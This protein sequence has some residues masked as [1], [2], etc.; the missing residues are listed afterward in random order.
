MKSLTD[1]PA[2]SFRLSDSVWIAEGR[3]GMLLS[4]LYLKGWC[5]SLSCQSPDLNTLARL[6]NFPLF[7]SWLNRLGWS[8]G[9]NFES[10]SWSWGLLGF[11]WVHQ[12]PL[13]YQKH[14]LRLIRSLRGVCE[15]AVN[16]SS[17]LLLLI[18]CFCAWLYPRAL[19]LG[20]F[21]LELFPLTFWVRVCILCCR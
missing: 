19:F 12:F 1:C 3:R 21:L 2:T 14:A 4:V 20:F 13:T 5:K 9:P 18:P 8:Q 11:V 7:W 17:C 6:Q 16:A 10:L 15:R